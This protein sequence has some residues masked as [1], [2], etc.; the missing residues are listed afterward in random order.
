MVPMVGSM[1]SGGSQYER[2]GKTHYERNKA[3]YM[4]RTKAKRVEVSAYLRSL[5]E[6]SGCIDCGN[7]DFRVLDFDHIGVKTIN[8]SQM[9]FKGWGRAR[10]DKELAQCVV[11]CSNC[12]RIVT[13]ERAHAVQTLSGDV[14]D[15][16]SS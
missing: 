5:K 15:F 7:K 3:D 10:I 16:Q 6:Q 11:R 2:N 14:L 4:A 1:V 9:V 8:P 13:Y 12:H